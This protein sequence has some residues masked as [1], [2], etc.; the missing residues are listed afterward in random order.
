VLSEVHVEGIDD[1]AS[2]GPNLASIDT[3]VALIL[4]LVD[5]LPVASA[6]VAELGSKFGL[7][8]GVAEDDLAERISVHLD[9]LD[10]R[11]VSVGWEPQIAVLLQVAVLTHD[12][13]CGVVDGEI[14]Q[15]ALAVK[16]NSAVL[17]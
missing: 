6:E 14:L 10:R 12:D 1:I 2:V 4:V 15:R 16:A 5:A 3:V 9:L 7:V 13:H 8:V 17:G 11:G